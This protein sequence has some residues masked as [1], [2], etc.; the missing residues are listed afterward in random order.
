MAA[1]ERLTN[2]FLNQ[3]KLETIDALYASDAIHHSPMGDLNIEGRKMTRMALGMALPDFQVGIVSLTT[4]E[5]WIAVLYS[6]SGTFTGNLPTPDGKQISGNSA[7]INLVIGS[8]LRFDSHGQI[9]E[10]W[11]TF[12]NLSLSTQMGLLPAS[13]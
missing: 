5:E 7:K 11:E 3:G 9:T 4:S 13:H 12:D 2:E 6:F 1:A 10:S 8:F